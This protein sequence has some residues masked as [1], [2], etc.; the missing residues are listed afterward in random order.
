VRAPRG[1]SLNEVAVVV[2]LLAIATGW[3]V[4]TYGNSMRS[5]YG[6]S[7]DQLGS[8]CGSSTRGS[9]GAT[10]ERNMT[11]FAD[12]NPAYMGNQGAN[13]SAAGLG[14]AA[15]PGGASVDPCATSGGA[16]LSVVGGASAVGN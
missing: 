12:Q 7:A 5:V 1:Q 14:S 3:A 16:A 10:A 8:P 13:S 11:N 4:T 15:Q 2:A 6:S 9:G